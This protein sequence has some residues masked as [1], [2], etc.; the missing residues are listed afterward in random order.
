MLK[1]TLYGGF[2]NVS[3]IDL[4]IKNDQLSIGQYKRLGNHMCGIKGCVCGWLGYEIEGI[5]K[6][7]FYE[8]LVDVNYRSF[9]K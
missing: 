5:N 8:M 7:V 9:C 6:N 1:V 3:R 4:R 2:H